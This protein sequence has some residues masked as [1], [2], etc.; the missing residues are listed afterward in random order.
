MTILL[1]AL[2]VVAAAAPSDPAAGIA[3]AAT[4]QAAMAC[5]SALGTAAGGELQAIAVESLR[6]SPTRTVLKGTIRVL[7]RPPPAPPGELS[8]AHVINAKM[9][10]QCTLSGPKVVKATVRRF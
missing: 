1:L 3:D 7:L 6:R 8:A 4:R 9:G 10:Y 5:E 2:G